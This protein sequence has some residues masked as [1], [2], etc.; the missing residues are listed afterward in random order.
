MAVMDATGPD[1]VSRR[2]W[3]LYQER[4]QSEVE[5]EHNGRFLVVDVDSGDYVL[6]DDELSAFDRARE[7]LP[8]G[9]F[10]LVRVGRRAA[11]RIGRLTPGSW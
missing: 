3:R 2:G 5:P 9:A 7:Q 6:A 10:Y 8:D 4:I 11:H 1:D